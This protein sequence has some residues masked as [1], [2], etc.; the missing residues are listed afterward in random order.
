M[1]IGFKFY[2]WFL[3]IWIKMINILKHLL[4]RL[5]IFRPH[6]KSSLSLL[7]FQPWIPIF[8]IIIRL[9]RRIAVLTWIFSFCTPILLW[10]CLPLF[11]T[12]HFGFFFLWILIN[13]PWLIKP[14]FATGFTF[15]PASVCWF[16][17]CLHL[18]SFFF[19]RF[20]HFYFPFMASFDLPTR[21]DPW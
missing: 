8:Q 17:W 4:F 5:V 10:C 6:L 14:F 12:G 20:L 15:G 21:F 18:N 2:Y 16:F 19:N 1:G 9:F 11:A 3:R 7:F 13:W